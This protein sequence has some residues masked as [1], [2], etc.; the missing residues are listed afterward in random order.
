MWRH[1]AK[2]SG[3]SSENLP[4][5][6]HL[7]WSRAVAPAR[8]AWPNEPRL[9]FDA[10][11]EPVVKGKR[12]F[13]GS[14]QDGGVRAY[15]TDSGKELWKFYTEGP[16][17]FAP[18]AW[19]D[20]LYVGSDDGFLYHL[21]AATGTLRWKVRGAPDDR[22]DYR[23][24]G[25]HRLISLWPLRGGPVIE[26]GVVYFGAGIWPTMGVFV[27]AINA[28]SGELK[29]A[30]GDINYLANVRIDHNTLNEAALSPQGYC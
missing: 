21:D 1:D 2:R 7:A 30:N 12:L 13:V 29:W 14:P 3:V 18:V 26:D 16:V 11:V 9:H 22:A 6:L 20:G 24:L 23:Q 10:S 28:K 4:E 19:E 5:A 15:D 25:N 17:R 8:V 27:K